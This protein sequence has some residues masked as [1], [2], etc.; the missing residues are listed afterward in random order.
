MVRQRSFG[1][2]GIFIANVTDLRPCL[3]CF[4][5]SLLGRSVMLWNGLKK[6]KSRERE[7]GPNGCQ[8]SKETFTHDRSKLLSFCA[9]P[10]LL[11]CNVRVVET[12]EKDREEAITI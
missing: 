10:S 12:I 11:V 1:L 8:R 7:N 5:A 6:L 4:W 2:Q 9:F 3:Y